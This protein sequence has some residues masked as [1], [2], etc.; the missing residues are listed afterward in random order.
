MSQQ[1]APPVRFLMLQNGE[2]GMEVLLDAGCA[3]AERDSAQVLIR[4][5]HLRTGCPVRL[6]D[7]GAKPAETARVRVLLG[8]TYRKG[9]IAELRRSGKIE[10]PERIEPEGYAIRSCPGE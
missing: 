6:V 1:L 5:F 3:T 8:A 9:R 10:L 7:G 2:A 4:Q